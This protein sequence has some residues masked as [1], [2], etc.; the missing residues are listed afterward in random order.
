MN[1]AQFFF[2][3]RDNEP[4]PDAD[5]T[6][7]AEVETPT[8]PYDPIELLCAVFETQEMRAVDEPAPLRVPP[9][10]WPRWFKTRGYG[11]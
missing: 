7:T 11:K 3:L 4:A 8:R 10:F 9:W 1:G 6:E 2:W 5:A